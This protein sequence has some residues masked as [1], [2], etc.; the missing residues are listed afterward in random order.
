MKSI[1]LSLVLFV[2]T[3][4]ATMAQQ[5]S[6]APRPNI[7]ILLADDLGSQD[8]GWR[9]SEIRTP[10]LDALAKDGARLE[11]FYVQPLCSPSR[12]ALL[13]GR[14]PFR[15]GLQVG[16]IRIF[17]QYGL[18]LTERTLP[19]ALKEAG[20][21]TA[22][23]GKWHL[24]SFDPAYLPTRRGFDHQYGLYQGDIDYFTHLR[25]GALD[26]HR[27]DHESHDTGYTTHLIAKEA[28]QRIEQRDK[29]KPLFLYVAFNSVHAPYEVPQKYA[30]PY[31]QFDGKRKIY[32]GMTT[33][34]DEAVGQIMDELRQQDMLKNTI[35]FF[36]S[37]NGGPAPGRITSNAPFRAGKGSVY[38]GG[39]RSPGVVYWEGHIKPG[40]VV[41]APLHIV[42][43]YPTMLTLAGAN[44]QQE[45]PLDGRDAWD[46]I[47]GGASSPHSEI[48][49]NSAPHSG[50]IRVGDWKLVYNPQRSGDFED[51]DE[52][53]PVTGDEAPA[54]AER[55][56]LYNLAD[57]PGEQHNLAAEKPDI[58]RELRERYDIIARTATPPLLDNKPTNFKIPRVWG[59]PD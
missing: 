12:A 20:Y 50:A 4:S 37:D 43:W 30:A 7:V 3:V 54:S 21:E 56:E 17:S 53:Q 26:W 10:N 15:Y 58:L 19:Q 47:T 39:V 24:G 59:Q 25:N 5:K 38:E 32:A 6:T 40:T 51:R 1:I 46:A 14:Y 29:S 2:A 57:D 41:N 28:I 13:T 18:P 36:A 27:D 9:G 33:F 16:V 55:I 34:L 8:V 49:L 42:D 45:L 22:I 48:V 11:Q 31:T 35:I 52:T 44:L 23:D